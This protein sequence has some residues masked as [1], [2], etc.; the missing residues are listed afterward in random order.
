MM[1]CERYY[2]CAEF[3][4]IGPKC[5]RPVRY[6]GKTVGISSCCCLCRVA[7]AENTRRH[8]QCC[9]RPY[10]R[11][12]RIRSIAVFCDLQTLEMTHQQPTF[13][14]SLSVVLTI[15]ITNFVKLECCHQTVNP[16]WRNLF[17]VNQSLIGDGK[18]TAGLNNKSRTHYS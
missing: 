7:T 10:V 12:Q 14:S 15:E 18:L 8:L 4:R 16:L 13:Y 11:S 5:R 9:F 17:N 2:N 6:F 3:C 1:R